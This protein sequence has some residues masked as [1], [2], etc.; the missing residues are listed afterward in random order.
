MLKHKQ[1]DDTLLRTGAVLQATGLSRTS[2]YRMVAEGNFPKPVHLSEK[3]RA[4]PASVVQGWIRAKKKEA[5][6]EVAK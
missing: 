6:Y 4:W 3:A 5:G 2:M 1:H